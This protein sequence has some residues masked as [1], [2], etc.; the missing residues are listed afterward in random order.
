MTRH[1]PSKI[2]TAIGFKKKGSTGWYHLKYFC[3]YQELHCVIAYNN[4][5]GSCCFFSVAEPD[6][7]NDTPPAYPKDQITTLQQLAAVL[8]VVAGIKITIWGLYRYRWI[9]LTI[10]P[11]AALAPEVDPWTHR[12]PRIRIWSRAGSTPALAALRGR[13]AFTRADHLTRQQIRQH[14]SVYTTQH[15]DNMY[16]TKAQNCPIQTTTYCNVIFCTPI[17]DICQ[18][19]LW[20]FAHFLSSFVY[21]N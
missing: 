6:D 15:I 5:S 13:I 12:V 4:K 20:Y 17:V 3:Q 16:F 8:Q 10:R 11:P 18:R 14:I 9:Q 19:S 2:L 7:T 1:I 21:T